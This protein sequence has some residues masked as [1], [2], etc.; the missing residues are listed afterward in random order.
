MIPPKDGTSW[1][2]LEY[3]RYL[4]G[5][6]ENGGLKK[7]RKAVVVPVALC[8]TDKSKFRSRVVVQYVCISSH[9]DGS[10]VAGWGEIMARPSRIKCCRRSRC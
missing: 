9:S 8:Y 10:N 5:T 7:G 6:P 1:A 2:A 3:L 4:E